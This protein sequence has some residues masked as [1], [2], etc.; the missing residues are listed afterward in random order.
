MVRVGGVGGGGGG[1]GWCSVKS[2]KYHM[3]SDQKKA[4]P[5]REKKVSP[6]KF[7]LHTFRKEPKYNTAVRKSNPAENIKARGKTVRPV[8]CDLDGAKTHS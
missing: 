1:R 5:Y 4:L 3:L 2:I 8:L 6:L 7:P